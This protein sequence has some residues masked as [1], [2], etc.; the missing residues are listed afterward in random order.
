MTRP[1][2]DAASL[3]LLGNE[4]RK[5][6]NFED[7]AASYRRALEVQPDYT[8]ALYNLGLVLLDLKRPQE[9]ERHF[10]RLREIEPR[11]AEAIFQLALLAADRSQPAEAAQL[12]RDA[13]KLA[14]DNPGIWLGL[15]FVCSGLPGQQ[16]EAVRCLRQCLQLDPESAEA[17]GALGGLLLAEGRLEE[18]IAHYRAGIRSEP[19]NA[20]LHCQLGNAMMSSGRP[21][22]AVSWYEKTLQLDPGLA[23][24]HLNLGSVH[25]L[26]RAHDRAIACYEAAL[27]IQPD[28]AAAR[29]NLLYEK[30]RICD[31]SRF[32][33]LCARQRLDSQRETEQEVLPFNLLSI[34]STAAEQLQCAKQY[35]TRQA[36]AVARD[37]ER[38][39]F[40]H[41][42]RLPGGR[43]RIGYLSADLREHPVASLVA[44]M[45]ELHD[46]SR[47][48]VLAYSYGPN[49]KSPMRRRLEQA[50]DRFANIAPLSHADAAT[51]IHAD[52]VNILVDLTGYTTFGRPEIASL[53]PAP[54]QVS[55]M[56]P[57]T[58]GTGFY[59]YI[60]TDRYVTPPGGEAYLSEKPV[61]MPGTY[62]ANDRKRTVGATPSR[63]E[64]GLPE[65]S[66]VFCCFNHTYKILPGMFAAWVRLLQ[67][68]P[69]SVLWL[70]KS[71]PW[72]EQN[73]LRE[74]QRYGVAAG[75]L[76]FAPLLPQAQHLGRLRAADLFL[77]TQ[78]Y[79][80]H[81]TASDALW[82]G[83]PVVTCSG[84]TFASRV[85]GSLLT[86]IGLP[87]LA[88]H[89]MEAYEALALRLARNPAE[90]SALRGKLSRNRDSTPLFDT[91][92]FTS[93][94]ETAYLQMWENHLAGNLPRAI[95]P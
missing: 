9:A 24:A 8:N 25:G 66:F 11:D 95:T 26:L 65:R 28:N 15:A 81:T 14:P 1:A 49:D 16:E 20:M 50:F 21:A 42:R 44:E 92:A 75:R 51:R 31:W 23:L 41:E 6:G 5:A 32:E 72:A 58:L 33:E 55:Y 46:R 10:R 73:L 64:L 56:F 2:E 53:R 70:L 60:L 18:A 85:A 30:Q 63:G 88:T 59:D 54:V 62:M 45:F 74:A 57:G 3:N 68:A 86:A 93:H 94:L 35:G 76:I 67:A 19:G 80:A 83:L 38:L 36:R 7:A 61:Y 87:E 39:A 77:D 22:D 91:P 43:L 47:F 40:R 90:L 34:P 29:G 13:L 89:S 78:P 84:D 27:R 82:A 37:R 71:N 79:N 4:R 52:G 17:H 48:E 69:D 12:Y